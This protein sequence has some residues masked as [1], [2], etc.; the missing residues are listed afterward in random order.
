M[1]IIKKQPHEIFLSSF[2]FILGTFRLVTTLYNQKVRTR[3]GLSNSYITHITEDKNG[4]LWFATEEGLNKLEGNYFTSFYKENKGKT[5]NLTGNELNCLLDDP[6]EPILWIGTQRAGLN[7]FNYQTNEQTIYQHNE[8]DP[9]SIATNDIT[10]IYPA[11]DGNLWI[12]TYWRGIEYLNKKT[13]KF[14]HYNQ[15]SVPEL[16]SN[17][18]WALIDDHKGNLYIGHA[19]N[20][21]SI[22]CLKNKQVRNFT[23]DKHNEKTIPSNNVQ[24]IFKDKTGNIW[25]GTEKGLALFKP[26]TEEFIRLGQKGSPLSHR[27]YDIKQFN[28]N[29]LWVA[30]EFG[31][32]AIINLSKSLFNTL[33]EILMI[34]AGDNEYCLNNS[35]VR[36]LFQDS[37]QNIWAG[38]WG[39]GVNFLSSDIALFKSYSYSPSQPGSNLNAHIASAVCLD[40]QGTLWVGTDGGG[41]NVL[42]DGKRVATYT[43]ENGNLSGNS[44]QTAL[45]DKRGNLWFGIFNGGIMYYDM[46]TQKFQQVFSEKEALL[47]VRSLFEDSDGIIWVG[48]SEGVFQ[49]E[50]DTRKILYH[51][52]VP[53]NLV[54]TVIKDRKGQVWVGSFGRGI[55]LYSPTGQRIKDFNTYLNFPSNTINQIF[56]DSQGVIWAATGEG[57]VQ[58]ENKSPWNYKIYQRTEG[59]AN[60]FIW[61]ITEDE[62]KNI[63][64]STNQG[65]SCLSEDRK[66]IYNY[67]Y[68]DNIPMASFTRSVCKDKNGIIYFGSTNG[69]CYF[70]PSHILEKKQS[71]QAVI[72]RLTVFEPLTSENSNETEISL[73]NKESVKLKY[74]QNNFN[75]SFSIQ[76]YSL[77]E[78]VEYAYMLKGL[79][80]SWYTVK[81]PDN[82]TF[83]N[84]PPGKYQFLVKTRIRNQE[85]SD[86]V[87]R[88]EIIVSPPIWLSWW[89]K[90][91]YVIVGIGILLEDSGDINVN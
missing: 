46:H 31:G 54:R 49:I 77:N 56:E 79:E 43:E 48:T 58:F 18:I 42:K 39:G 75:I 20:G 62:N 17:T 68:R 45:C 10:D 76:D 44:V 13:G 34:Q 55:F 19:Q 63:W 84:L 47:D 61:A 9:Y 22:L 33:E 28:E 3:K 2:L 86:N 12:T 91:L 23:Y 70:I 80:N 41:I 40:R 88:L 65:I 74:I 14:T 29:Q 11:K 36:C 87:T 24:C 50:R 32:I 85:W 16:P 64:F 37:H 83:R 25:V 78:R 59:L 57:I 30:T 52:N 6:N 51:M 35:T 60:T 89:A 53:D 1:N 7:A 26:D 71:P 21:M 81:D 82:V 15:Q 69:L 4:Y 72:G 66:D 5:L 38:T 67:D 8:S 27:I 73:I 90:L